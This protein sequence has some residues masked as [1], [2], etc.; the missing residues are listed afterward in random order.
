MIGSYLI[1]AGGAVIGAVGSLI[2]ISRS[3]SII[4]EDQT[5]SVAQ[6][7]TRRL[8]MLVTL[9]VYAFLAFV[10]TV[11]AL[12]LGNQTIMIIAAALFL[13]AVAGLTAVWMARAEHSKVANSV[14]MRPKVNSRD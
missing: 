2:F 13:C 7:R 3:R 1:F 9:G 10:C 14:D 8:A 6:G 5:D 12:A 4:D 11:I